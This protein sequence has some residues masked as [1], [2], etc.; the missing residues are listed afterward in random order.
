MATK[1][2]AVRVVNKS[3]ARVRAGGAQ[4]GER[5]GG[6]GGVGGGVSQETPKC[7]GCFHGLQYGLSLTGFVLG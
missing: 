6:G 4:R 3:A 5:R 2:I 1:T 7:G